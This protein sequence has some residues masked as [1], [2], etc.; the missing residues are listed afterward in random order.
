MAAY[1][2][3]DIKRFQGFFDKR[4]QIAGEQPPVQ[5]KRIQQQAVQE[6]RQQRHRTSGQDGADQPR[7]LHQLEAV[8]E[9]QSSQEGENRQEAEGEFE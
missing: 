5:G 8:E 3:D 6:Q 4:R 7:P 2:Q 1:Q 9:L